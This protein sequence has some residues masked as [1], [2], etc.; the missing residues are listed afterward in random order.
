MILKTVVTLGDD[1][2]AGLAL[3]P[4]FGYAALFYIYTKRSVSVSIFFSIS[5]IIVVLF[6]FGMLDVLKLAT[7]ILFYGGIIILF[8]MGFVFKNRLYV[9]VKSVPFVVYTISSLVYLYLMKDS[10]LFFWDE[11]SHWGVFIKE[12]YFFDKFYDAS[13]GAANLMYPPGISIW[14][15]FLVKPTGYSEGGLYFAYFLIL[16]SSTLMMYEKVNY[17]E[18]HWIGLIFILQIVVFATYGHWFSSIYVDHVVGAFFL[19]IVLVY[20]V[21]KFNQK[22]LLLF[23]FPLISLVLLKEIG[24]YFGAVFVGL[25]SILKFLESKSTDDIKVA[26]IVGKQKYTILVLVVLLVSMVLVLK[27]WEMRQQLS[28]LTKPAHSMSSVVEKIV[29]NKKAFSN[30]ELTQRYNNAF[31]DVVLNQ[32]LHKEKISLNY[33]E[34]SYSIMPKFK[35]ILKLSTIG[36][37]IFLIFLILMRL[38]LKDSNQNSYK[39]VIVGGY[40]LFAGLFYLAI[41]YLSM[42]LSL[43]ANA[44]NMVSYVRY[45]NMYMMPLIF[46]G[47]VFFLPL[48]YRQKKDTSKQFLYISTILALFIFITE[49]YLKPMYSQ[50]KSNIRGDIDKVSKDILSIVPK[51]SKLFVIFPIKNNGSLN[52]IIKYTLIPSRATI[53]DYD[54]GKLD[55]SKMI[56]IFLQYD[57]IWFATLNNQLVDKNR[58]FLRQKKEQSLFTLY[59]IDQKQSGVSIIPVW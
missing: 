36:S 19:G 55:S 34:F 56:Q 31:V 59:K 43:G 2:I 53:S 25:V 6:L 20:F 39:I 30:K 8:Y 46:M 37:F 4:I 16:F 58:V 7:Y 28:G 49:P 10:Q 41:L 15:Y 11:Y 38:R 42:P 1:M 22:E 51:N 3:L 40:L 52:N 27:S 21:D 57:Y 5:S 26:R 54:F 48:Y 35:K 17:K 29:K 24:L 33:N 23:I 32:Q 18:V 44:I 50:L 14:D 9:A 45:I 47:F 12:M 13:S